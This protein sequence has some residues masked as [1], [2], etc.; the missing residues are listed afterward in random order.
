MRDPPRARV[1]VVTP[2]EGAQRD[3]HEA[4]GEALAVPPR[5]RHRNLYIYILFESAV[6]RICD[7]V[8]APFGQ[9]PWDAARGGVRSRN[10]D[11][12]VDIFIACHTCTVLQH[13]FDHVASVTILWLKS[14][15]KH[16]RTR[17]VAEQ[18]KLFPRPSDLASAPPPASAA[19]S[20]PKAGAARCAA[21][22]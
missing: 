18:R 3:V 11:S 5:S 14:E 4:M 13:A 6:S 8:C 19:G 12:H 7:R 1:V 10:P 16:S 22:P 2:L 21:Q 15:I 9:C 20:V 17:M